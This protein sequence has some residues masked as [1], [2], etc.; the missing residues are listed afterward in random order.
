KT[1]RRGVGQ[2]DFCVG[3]S[4]EE[5][6]DERNFRMNNEA[7]ALHRARRHPHT[8]NTAVRNCHC[9]NLRAKRRELRKTDCLELHLFAIQEAFAQITQGEAEPKPGK[10]PTWFNMN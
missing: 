10:R 9:Y 8:V 7:I 1:R 4:N 2:P 3:H 6:R 5:F